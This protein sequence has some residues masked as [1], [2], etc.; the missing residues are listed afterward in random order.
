MMIVLLRQLCHCHYNGLSVWNKFKTV[1]I[2]YRKFFLCCKKEDRT[3]RQAMTCVVRVDRTGSQRKLGFAK[4]RERTRRYWNCKHFTCPVNK[5]S[6]EELNS[7]RLQRSTNL[8]PIHKNRLCGVFSTPQEGYLLKLTEQRKSNRVTTVFTRPHMIRSVTPR[9]PQPSM[10]GTG[11]FCVCRVSQK[12]RNKS[13]D[14]S[15]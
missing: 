8:S 4:G 13:K 11:V 15:I 14:L 9:R 10:S 2:T 12:N 6:Y 7:N 1:E 5:K 3:L